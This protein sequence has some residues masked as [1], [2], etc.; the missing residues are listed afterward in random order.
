MKKS[1]IEIKN[2]KKL[3]KKF[4]KCNITIKYKLNGYLGR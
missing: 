4:Y 1:E 2:S 3:K